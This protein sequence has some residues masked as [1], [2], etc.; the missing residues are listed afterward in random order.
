MA[1]HEANAAESIAIVGMAARFPGAANIHQFWQNLLAGIES[2]S[3]F[4]DEELLESGVDPSDLQHP[5]YVKAKGFLKDAD[6]FDA[7]FFNY[8]P[9]ESEMMDPQQRVLL[10]T[11][12]TALEDAGCNPERFD[13]DIGVFASATQN[14]YLIRQLMQNS[15]LLNDAN[16]YQMALANGNDFLATRISYNLNLRGPAQTIQT[17]CSSSLVAVHYAC[18]SLFNYECDAALAGGVSITSPLKSGYIYKKEGI[19][20]P[21]GH[22]RPFDALANGTLAANGSGMVVLKRLSDAIATNDRIY[23]VIKG[24]A[25]NNDGAY[26][27]GYTAPSASGQAKVIQLAQAVANTPAS[28]IHYV[29]A[30]G[31]GTRVGDPIEFSGLKQAFDESGMRQW[32]ALGSVKGNIGHLDAAAGI[33]GIIKTALSLYHGTIPPSINFSSPNAEIN[34]EDSPFFVNTLPTPWSTHPFWRAGVSSFGIGGTNAHAILEGIP[35][36][37]QERVEKA[38][39]YV[40]PIAAKTSSAL[41]LMREEL[42]KYLETNPDIYL[43]DVA[44]T[45]RERRTAHYYREVLLCRKVAGRHDIY[46]FNQDTYLEEL[47][48]EEYKRIQVWLTSNEATPLGSASQENASII[49]LP[50]YPFKKERFWFKAK[51]SVPVDR[52]VAPTTEKMDDMPTLVSELTR[53]LEELTG[54]PQDPALPLERSGI[55]SMMCIDYILDIETQLKIDVP[56]D[57]IALSRSVVQIAQILQP[58]APPVKETIQTSKLRL[59]EKHTITLKEGNKYGLPLFCIHPA[60]G[61]INIFQELAKHIKADQS[62]IGIRALNGSDINNNIASMAHI[63]KKEIEAIQP[64]GPYLLCGSSM[65]GTIAFE[66]AQ[67][68]QE[69][70]KTIAILAMLDTPPPNTH[71]TIV[72]HTDE[73]IIAYLSELAPTVASELAKS[74]VNQPGVRKQFLEIWRNHRDALMQYQGRSYVGNITYFKAKEMGVF[75]NTHFEHGWTPLAEEG[76]EIHEVPG[77]HLSMHF[78]PNVKR[79]AEVLNKKLHMIA[80]QRMIQQ[81]QWEQGIHYAS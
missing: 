55:D 5:R 1:E 59:V 27:A 47:P 15:N 39:W 16:Y 29:E 50:A 42:V 79:I 36:V 71:F 12:Y 35:P 24:S 21:D 4:S 9:R 62:I 41:S 7:S 63:Y 60:G 80:L 49:S 28:S 14:T 8:T 25:I 68:L 51:I 43:P 73:E 17:G 61:A 20:S 23:A 26:K 78:S 30:H 33:A 37:L 72:P 57:A 77:N 75:Q 56:L 64:E 19:A 76:I 45:L 22:C 66:I 34:F 3:T 48:S 69:Q 53:I 46:V 10:E 11:A 67:L 65:G 70:G 52:N 38:A 18:Q 74:E 44:Y 13:G 2:I 32:C 58:K 6:C 40:L 54:C 31:T 81:P